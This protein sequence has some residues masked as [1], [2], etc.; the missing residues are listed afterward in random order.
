MVGQGLVENCPPGNSTYPVIAFESGYV[1][2]Q[3]S[4]PEKKKNW[5]WLWV[6]GK[7]M[8]SSKLSNL[9]ETFMH[10]VAPKETSFNKIWLVSI[11]G[12]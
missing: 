4:I 12:S 1:S 3:D 11:A 6:A 10:I 2:S 8:L 9:V 5:D 7:F